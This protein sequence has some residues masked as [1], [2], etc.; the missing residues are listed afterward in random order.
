TVKYLGLSK[1]S[2]SHEGTPGPGRVDDILRFCFDFSALQS[3]DKKTVLLSDWD[4]SWTFAE[5]V[6]D[7][8]RTCDRKV[9][10]VVSSGDGWPSSC[11][12]EHIKV[13]RARKWHYQRPDSNISVFKEDDGRTPHYTF[14]NDPGRVAK[15]LTEESED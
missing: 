8:L 10:I 5:R 4:F 15:E 12:Q 7:V 6:I 2:Q 14:T 11:L 9:T 1:W 3:G 13:L